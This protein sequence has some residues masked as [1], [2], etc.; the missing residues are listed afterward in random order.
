M[1]PEILTTA[2]AEIGNRL[3]RLDPDSAARLAPLAGK[4][5]LLQSTSPAF[6]LYL[7]P[8]DAGI[9]RVRERHDAA[10]DVV[11]RGTLGAF[12]RLAR[13]GT[14]PDPALLRA[15]AIEGDIEAG[16]R[17]LSV[18]SRLDIDWEEQA[19]QVLG[20][21]AAHQL[22][23]AVRALHRFGTQAVSTLVRDAGEY[24]QHERRITPP[25]A[26]VEAFLDAVD[27]LRADVDRLEQRML[28]LRGRAS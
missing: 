26:Q 19:A 21:V 6:A 10:P 25:R 28:R 3:V 14:A 9:I 8:D 13:P 17:L 4:A 12:V 15:V 16:Q 2:L 22:G 27:T 5:I 23:N 18:F 20:D 7:L 11:V 24:L 1:I